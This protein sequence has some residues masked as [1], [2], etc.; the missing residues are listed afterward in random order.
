MNPSP[1]SSFI[2]NVIIFS[3]TTPYSILDISMF[4]LILVWSISIGVEKP[5]YTLSSDDDP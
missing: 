4:S 2:V 3:S 5:P 1:T